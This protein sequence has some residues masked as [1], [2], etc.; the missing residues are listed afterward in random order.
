MKYLDNDGAS[1]E[2]CECGMM[3]YRKLEIHGHVI[4]IC[5]KCVCELFTISRE[6]IVHGGVDV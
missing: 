2:A 6:Q 4:P 5:G 1:Y 3:T